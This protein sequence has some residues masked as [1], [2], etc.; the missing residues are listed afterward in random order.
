M[1]LSSAYFLVLHWLPIGS[2]FRKA[3]LWLILGIP[4]IWWVDLQIDGVRRGSLAHNLA[5]IPQ[6]GTVIAAT[7]TSPLDPLYLGAVFDGIF[8]ISYPSSPH[9]RQVT[10][11]GAILHAFSRPAE[12]PPRGVR[13]V[14]I[15]TLLDT[16]PLRPIVVFPESTT[17]NGRGILRLSPSLLSTPA[18]VKI[19]PVSLR[20]T[21]ADVTVPIPHA[22]LSFLW[23]LLSSPTHSLR[24]RIAEAVYTPRDTSAAVDVTS[25]S[26]RGDLQV[27]SAQSQLLD[28]VGESLARLGRVNYLGLG[29]K[30][31]QEF[32]KIWLHR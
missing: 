4:G 21:A 25:V 12:Q 22:Y 10:L 23:H 8:T 11:L 28:K 32:L 27:S 15:G 3:M 1:S 20:W 24:T 16:Y 7:L 17:T 19:F 2:L 29:V 26:E 14:D 13:L 30:E 5:R 18:N 9:L 6:A 31:K